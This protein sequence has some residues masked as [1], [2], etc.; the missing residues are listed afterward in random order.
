M[1]T[2]VK[3]RKNPGN[4]DYSQVSNYVSPIKKRTSL[5]DNIFQCPTD[6]RESFL[7]PFHKTAQHIC[8]ETGLP[9]KLFNWNILIIYPYCN[10]VFIYNLPKKI[11]GYLGNL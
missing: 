5:T 9:T 8:G 11:K 7:C 6:G 1:S 3:K 4:E 10:T 2:N